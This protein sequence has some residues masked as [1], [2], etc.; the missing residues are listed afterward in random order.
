M[1]VTK[2]GVE[3]MV[4]A[5]T[6]ADGY[7]ES[8]HDCGVHRDSELVQSLG[9]WL[10]TAPD[11]LEIPDALIPHLRGSVLWEIVAGYGH[12]LDYLCSDCRYPK[13]LMTPD[14]ARRDYGYNQKYID[15]MLAD[16]RPDG[17]TKHSA[18]CPMCG[19]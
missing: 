14:E 1:I 4:L 13:W 8:G 6:G 7:G 10:K 3:K 2:A 12:P 11:S 17:F 15:E 5:I 16:M 9:M 18:G 19:D